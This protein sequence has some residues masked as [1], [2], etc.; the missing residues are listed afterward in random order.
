MLFRSYPA[1][2]AD[3]LKVSLGQMPFDILSARKAAIVT[4]SEEAIADATR[5]VWERLKIIIEPS[6]AVVV[7]AI[8]EKKVDVAGKRVGLILSG[9]NVDLGHLPWA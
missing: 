9:G 1:T 5:Y 7:A 2:I 4:V 8:A 6:S 3:G